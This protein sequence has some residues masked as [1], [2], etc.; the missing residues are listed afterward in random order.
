M[1]SAHLMWALLTVGVALWAL[2]L[3]REPLPSPAPL[4]A[5]AAAGLAGLYGAVLVVALAG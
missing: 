1:T 3:D 2:P 5:L 4:A